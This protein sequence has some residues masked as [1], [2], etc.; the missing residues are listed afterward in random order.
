MTV[1]KATGL[2]NAAGT[3]V[4]INSH[5]TATKFLFAD[6]EG[7]FSLDLTVLLFKLRSLFFA[8]IYTRALFYAAVT[9]SEV[10][11]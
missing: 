1:N 3:I 5:V 6:F 9:K 11:K 2:W 7:P 4:Y 10:Q 8:P